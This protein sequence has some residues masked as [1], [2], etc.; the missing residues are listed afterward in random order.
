[1]SELSVD[2]WGKKAWHSQP[3][4]NNGKGTPAP[5]Q[6]YVTPPFNRGGWSK[7]R[8]DVDHIQHVQETLGPA[9]VHARLRLIDSPYAKKPGVK[10]AWQ[11]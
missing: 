6:T 10:P 9:S 4:K 8:W 3:E 2:I 7:R 5:Y 11:D 1:M